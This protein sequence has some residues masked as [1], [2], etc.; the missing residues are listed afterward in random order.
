MP[1]I[2]AFLS[3][4]SS[5]WTKIPF[6]GSTT[7][8]LSPAAVAN[9][10]A[11]FGMA[12]ACVDTAGNVLVSLLKGSTWQPWNTVTGMNTNMAVSLASIGGSLYVYAVESS[13]GKVYF[14]S[15]KNGSNWA[16]S[17]T[18]IFYGAGKLKGVEGQ[19]KTALCAAA[20]GRVYM[21]NENGT[22][23]VNSNPTQKGGNEIGSLWENI[24]P[25]F[26]TDVSV[27]AVT[28][29]GVGADILFSKGYNNQQISFIGWPD[30]PSSSKWSTIPMGGL[31]N[32]SVAGATALGLVWLFMTGRSNEINF[33]I[34]ESEG[35]WNEIAGFKTNASVAAAAL[36]E[37]GPSGGIGVQVYVFAKG[38]TSGII[39]AAIGNVLFSSL[40]GG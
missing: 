33:S 21:V 5:T 17:W 9:P 18:E 1:T 25:S 28:N 36:I 20:S 13:S 37:N 12:V 22:I 19:T 23:S 31:T 15:T 3:F 39:H 24:N 30:Q 2:N 35:I 14:N 8:T 4:A 40:V 27:C 16:P 11:G 38:E 34:F 32:V 10:V 29:D 6:A 7:T 26:Q